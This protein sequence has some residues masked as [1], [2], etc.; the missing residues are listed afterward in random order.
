MNDEKHTTSEAECNMLTA[1]KKYAQFSGRSTRQ[2]FWLFVLFTALVSI[3]L[4]LLNFLLMMVL[5][6]SDPAMVDDFNFE[7]FFVNLENIPMLIP[8]TVISFAWR[9]GILCPAAAVAVRRMND[10]GKNAL[11]ALLLVPYAVLMLTYDLLPCSWYN[12]NVYVLFCIGIL[13]FGAAIAFLVLANGKSL[14][15]DEEE[16]AETSEDE[17]EAAETSEDEEEAAETS[18][19]EEE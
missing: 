13:A 6:W 12:S 17:E 8:F 10:V 3:G 1:L 11:F 18:E 9:L 19:D 4:T 7:N 15:E 2:E 14:P 16:A 5:F